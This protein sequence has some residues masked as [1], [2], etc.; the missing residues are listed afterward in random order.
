MR[1]SLRR[2]WKPMRDQIACWPTATTLF[3][4]L[5]LFLILGTGLLFGLASIFGVW[6]LTLPAFVI[7]PWLGMSTERL[8]NPA[9]KV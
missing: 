6:D 8:E 1:S 3:S 7:E 9:F 2:F 5:N 4:K